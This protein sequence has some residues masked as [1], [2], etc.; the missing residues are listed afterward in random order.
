[1]ISIHDQRILFW[2][3]SIGE[4]SDYTKA[5][6]KYDSNSTSI[7]FEADDYLYIGSFLPFNNRYFDL[8]LTNAVANTEISIEVWNNKE[9]KPVVDILDFTSESG[10]SM[11]QSESV[12]FVPDVDVPWHLVDRSK[13]NSYMTEFTNGP[14]IYSKYWSRIGFSQD[15]TIGINYIGNLFCDETELLDEYPQ[16]RSTAIL[17][18]WKTGKTNWKDQRIAA[19]EYIITDL[20]ERNI[21][22]ERGQIIETSILKNANI[23]KTAHNIYQGLGAKNYEAEI[24]NAYNRYKD[25]MTLRKF[26]TDKNSNAI[27][28][29]YETNTSVRLM[30]R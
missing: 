6:N 18:S 13:T 19:A 5:I 8:T 22:C 14:E 23:H 12:H 9:W 15:I 28:E 24:S 4:F 2:D 27:K 1:M 16:L 25:S 11:S 20:R 29:R 26:E 21:I 17:N 7:S 3:S 30:T 10:I